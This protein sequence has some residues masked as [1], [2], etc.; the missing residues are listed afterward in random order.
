MLKLNPEISVIMSVNYNLKNYMQLSIES[1]LN[2]SFKNFE[3]I[4]VNDGNSKI[5]SE[6]I[7][8]Y[9]KK[10]K[11]IV[12]KYTNGI[13]LTA[14]LNYAI[15]FAKTNYIAR[16]DYD[17]ISHSNRLK[18]QYNFL[19]NNNDYIF[20]A[21]N[22]NYI[23]YL[24]K[25]KKNKFI[26]NIFNVSHKKIKKILEYKNLFAHSSCMFQKNIFE[27]CGK[28]D[29]YFFYTQDYDLW[30]RM[31][32]YGKFIKLKNK[33]LSL[34]LHSNSISSKK[35]HKQRYYSFFIGLKYLC[36]E[37]S[38]YTKNINDHNFIN[39]LEKE[40]NNNSK[41]INVIKARKYVFLYDEVNIFNFFSYSLLIQYKIIKLYFNRP[42]YLIY[43]FLK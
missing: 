22:V 42:A 6:I 14:S 11:R 27:E 24:G 12:Y 33:L 36:P 30:T 40:F 1:I 38:H 39:T 10:D 15:S 18:I 25:T 32:Q 19:K 28:Y 20:C 16:Q 13:G 2:Q 5:I 23:N 21:S 17:D 29:E 37:I 3:F 43:R 35:N 8:N 26:Q 34:R 7:G 4:I 41:I 9:L 31:I